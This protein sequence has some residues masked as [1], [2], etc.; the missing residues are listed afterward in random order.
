M[1]DEPPS[2]FPR[3]LRR[4]QTPAEAKL[5]QAVRGGRLDGL[6]FRRQHRIAGYIADFACEPLC[7]VVELIVLL[8]G[9][10][11]HLPLQRL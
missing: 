5:W 11:L 8:P 10:L 1:D 6:K 2:H 9:V 7:L 4:N 3:S